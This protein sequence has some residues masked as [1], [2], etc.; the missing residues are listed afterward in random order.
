[1]TS[2]GLARRNAFRKPAR[3]ALLIF[4][5]ASAFLIQALLSSFVAGVDLQ[6]NGGGRL[7]VANASSALQ[8]LPLGD[9]ARIERLPG[10][11]AVSPTT[12]MRG[13]VAT[14]RNVIGATAVDPDRIAAVFGQ[15]LTLEPDLISALKIA[16]DNVLVGRALAEAQGWKVDQSRY[17]YQRSV[18]AKVR[19]A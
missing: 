8:P 12:R 10:V 6:S 15:E 17:R 9:L 19:L 5:I 11:A 14:E 2:F 1:M 7:V 18:R 13:Y 16:R 4:S 3:L